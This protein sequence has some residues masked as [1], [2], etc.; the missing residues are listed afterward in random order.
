MNRFEPIRRLAIVNRGEA[1]MR[2]IRAVKALRAEE[3]SDLRAVALY[4]AIDR[5]AP[6][7]RHA[8]LSVE[9]PAPRGEVAAYLDHEGLLAALRKVG[10]DAVWPGWGFVAESPEFVER[11]AAS[12]IRFLGPSPAAMRALGDKIGSKRIAEQ[13]GVPVTPWSGGELADA[14]AAMEAA[15]K[16]G[17]PLVVKASAGGGGRGIRVVEKAEELEAA[18]QS[19]QSEAQSAF[20]DG[21]L[22]V[23]Q[24]VEGGRHI[25]VQIAADSDGLVLAL[26]ARDC[27]VQRRHQKV[28]EEAPPPD[29]PPERVEALLESARQLA[30]EVG[31]A[32][33]GTVEFL[34]STEGFYFLEMNP[35]LQVEHGITEAITG[36]DLVQIQIRI[37]RGE[38]ISTVRTEQRGHA[39]EARVCAEDPD[40][41]FLPAPGRIARFD[42]A[43]GPGLRVDTGVA[44]G[45]QVPAAFD[46]LIA[47][48]I[49]IGRNREEARA[50]MA[51]ALDDFDLV[52]EGGATNKG[53]LAEVVDHPDYRKGGVDTTWLDR[54]NA[55]RERA[56]DFGMPALVAAAILAYQRD[57]A[58]ARLNFF[59]D[60]AQLAA[61]RVPASQGQEIDLSL[62]GEQYR[63]HVF[64]VG[65]WRYRV[66]LDGRVVA[67]ALREEGANMARLQLGE[68]T[69]RVL[70]DLGDAVLRVE[71][72][73]RAFPFASQS[74]GQVRAAAPAMVVAIH[75][76]PGD[77]VAAGQRLG[78]LEA[79]KMEV[80]F[81]APVAG[82]V[83]EVRAR[84]GEQVAAGDVI[85]VIEPKADAETGE[86]GSARLTLAELADPL[87]PLFRPE[88]GERLA[89][90]DLVSA[91]A[92][93][94]IAR[95]H[96]ID[97]VREETRRVLLGYDANP[98]RADRLAEF[99]EAPLPEGLSDGFRAELAEVR[100]EVVALADV[101][102][103]FVRSPGA[104]VSGELGPSNH[105]RL[106]M[107]ARRVRAAGAGIAE[108]FL[109]LVKRALAHYGIADLEPS[110]AL[111]RAMLRLLASQEQP[112][113]RDR[114][115]LACIHR[116]HAL[117][118]AGAN[119]G[120]DR[121]LADA[122][123][124]IARLRGL[125]S[126]AVAEAAIEARYVIFERPETEREA[127]RTS[128]QLQQWL[129]TAETQ[130]TAPPE[131]VL[132]HLADA[133]RAIFERV[134]SW[135]AEDDPRRRRIALA[136]HLRRIYSPAEPVA[137]AFQQERGS[138]VM[139]MD[140]PGG[141]IV[142]GAAAPVAELA[143][144]AERALA[145][146]EAARESHE[147]PAVSAIE[148]LVADAGDEP[149][150]VAALLAPVLAGG[151]PAGRLT[152]TLVRPGGPDLHRSFVPTPS[153][154]REDDSLHGIHPEAAARIDLDRL[155]GF[156][157]TRLPAAEP[158]YAF[159][160]ESRAEP[161]DERIFVLGDLRTR[162][163]EA[164]REASLHMPAF[165]Y[166]FYEA[167][168]ALRRILIERDPRRRL[169]W[170]RIAIYV[171]TEVFLE[172]RLVERLS[173][174]LEPA[175]RNLGLE[176]VVV[177]LQ[178]LDREAPDEPART[179]EMVISNL[180][181]SKMTIQARAPVQGQ[182]SPTSAYERKVVEARR[183]RL[184]YPYEIIRMLTGSGA[185]PGMGDTSLPRGE[186]E[187][188]DLD[189]ASAA[190]RAISVAGRPYGKNACG[191]VFGVITTPTE[192]V[193]EGM[194]RVIVLSDP[195]RGMGSLA[196]P[197]CDRIVAAL[198]LAE[199][200]GVP[201]EWLPVSSGARI[202][203]DSG[204]ENLDATARVVRRIIQFTQAGGVIHLIVNGVNVG[205]QSYWDALATMMSYARGVLIMTPNA[206]MVLTGRAALEASGAVSAEDETAI[207]GFERIMG[208]NGEA[209]YQASDLADAYRILYDHYRYT[210]VVPGERAPRTA[211]S[212]DPPDRFVGE[213]ACEAGCGFET[214]AE[215]FDDETNPGR[216][217][218]FPMRSVMRAVI[219]QDG[220]FLERWRTWVGAETAIVW[221][222]QL[223]GR[224]VCLIGIE[225]QNLA[226]EGYRPADGPASWTG[227]TL[228]PLS[229]KKVARA[230]NAAS[231][232]RPAV[233]L[234][235][236]SGFDG[237]PESMRKLQLELGAEIA[238][239]VVNF[240]GPILF[241]VVSRYHGG[242][243]VVF[244]RELNPRLR[245]SALEG[246]YA[247]VIGGGPAAAVVFGRDVRAR[248]L[249][250]PRVAE[251]AKQASAS[252]E[253][254]ARYERTFA[255]VTLEK[256]AELAAEFDAV[257]SVERAR[258]VGSLEEIVAP[259][260]MRKYLIDLLAQE[261]S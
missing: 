205:A 8:D 238:R 23:E 217:R 239:A 26:G 258:E 159:H 97:A 195:T 12:G 225:S 185:T 72:E 55:A 193:P 31:Y 189:A 80:G 200:L 17:F 125:L 47:K 163:P 229:S 11:L 6:F 254:R 173:R 228:F 183:R 236:L 202:A 260:G 128:Q 64:A 256:Q 245:A 164:G 81:D 101:A 115:A 145:V 42:P 37:A 9:L 232:N 100:H 106:R 209:Q 198:D 30:A 181:G 1:A 114:L 22:F 226:R 13:A 207:G 10:A 235:N 137:Q 123:D 65:S 84:R 121:Q 176:K 126:H 191:V 174:R 24:K 234:A 161:G 104:S 241:L 140:L 20:G 102:R 131:E 233:I 68:R 127:E 75:V 203:M 152:V 231:G 168:R 35:R 57:R 244:S 89:V 148:L 99:L 192:K 135:L 94:G 69:Y 165:E 52:I 156:E 151:L 118:L 243:Y 119:L 83:S 247:S 194:R 90:P 146:A 86:G 46:S 170:N 34:V 150:G 29:L 215:I 2:C 5:D 36:L 14:D 59:T 184:V 58:N 98:D 21:R 154:S 49:A 88:A 219:D 108:E 62:G 45:S 227:G 48:V 133:P 177:R 120:S 220:G 116:V 157:L 149:R 38:T 160:G 111:E 214:V 136:A 32:G 54:F 117:A 109:E 253:A 237:S 240:T 18:F 71:V 249:A 180:T 210:Y 223:G 216:K 91:D 87:E 196:A 132:Q 70:H 222:A 141:R 130:P 113:M 41:G 96:A 178:L 15:E 242:A 95:R 143:K 61:A 51:A 208:P 129:D 147:W 103:L 218:P 43:L 167:T 66:H 172:E 144:A 155:R 16:I 171:A 139:R 186:F 25:E 251:L 255:E 67:A 44:T 4:T 259:A 187:E 73:G 175:T 252:E 78:L 27:S 179:T 224:P 261:L 206:S 211:P 212:S 134:G 105:A 60:P 124:Q 107:Y 169:H 197:E 182:L 199:T 221:D 112:E 250:D 248:A 257:H 19:A 3:G 82:V 76:Q 33:V 204:T 158:L 166:L 39:I 85:V 56:D 63:V 230:L 142:L 201:V 110:A 190:P 93:P 79:M 188:Y 77:E 122:L 7:V 92:M 74:A 40:A 153:G 28:L 162:S 50:R 138:W 246:S 213:E 53:W